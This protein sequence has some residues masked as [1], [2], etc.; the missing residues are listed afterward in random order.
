MNFGLAF[1]KFGRRHLKFRLEAMRE[2]AVVG[3]ADIEGDLFDLA[4][5]SRICEH[6][7][8]LFDPKVI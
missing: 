2:A 4:K 3:Y 7:R 6:L 5:A 1:A 8:R